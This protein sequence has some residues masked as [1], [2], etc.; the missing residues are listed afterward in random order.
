MPGSQGVPI[1][2]LARLGSPG[3]TPQAV[4]TQHVWPIRAA[5]WAGYSWLVVSAG[6]WGRLWGRGQAVGKWG[7]QPCAV[8][9]PRY[10]STHGT[11][12]TDSQHGLHTEPLVTYY[13]DA[14]TMGAWY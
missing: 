12:G 7:Q 1:L 8:E 9:S 11:P 6:Q 2:C 4:G 14:I 3:M 5:P 10:K 13:K